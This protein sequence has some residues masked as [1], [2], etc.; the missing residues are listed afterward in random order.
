MPRLPPSVSKAPVSIATDPP[1]VSAVPIVVT[2]STVSHWPDF[3]CTWPVSRQHAV[4]LHIVRRAY[5]CQPRILI[6]A[7]VP[8]SSHHPRKMV[9]DLLTPRL[10][11]RF[12]D[13]QASLRIIAKL[14]PGECRSTPRLHSAR[15]HVSAHVSGAGPRRHCYHVDETALAPTQPKA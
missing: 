13:G 2:R 8:I 14:R 12:N 4:G 15:H 3:T 10:A 1:D 11:R 9:S 6:G 5:H 7:H